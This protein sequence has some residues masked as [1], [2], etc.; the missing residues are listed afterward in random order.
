MHLLTYALNMLRKK[1]KNIFV[2]FINTN[3]SVRN[4]AD[5]EMFKLSCLFNWISMYQKPKMVFGNNCANT[6]TLGGQPSIK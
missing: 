1:K 2:L 5:F 3:N 4:F 6:Y